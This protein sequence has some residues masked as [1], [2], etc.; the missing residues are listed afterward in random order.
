MVKHPGTFVTG[1]GM[2]VSILKE[3]NTLYI[4]GIVSLSLSLLFPLLSIIREPFVISVRRG[5]V[6]P[7]NA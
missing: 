5:C 2:V 4:L 7:V 3:I 1:M 6:I